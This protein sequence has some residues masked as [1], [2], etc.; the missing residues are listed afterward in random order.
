MY[1]IPGIRAPLFVLA[2]IVLGAAAVA[3]VADDSADEVKLRIGKGD[4]VLG[5]EI[6]VTEL[7]QEC[8]ALD[9]NSHAPATPKLAGQYSQYIIKQLIDLKKGARKHQTMN[10][11]AASLDDADFVD[12]AAYYASLK[13]MKGDAPRNLPKARALFE[14]GDP[15]R[16]VPS[17]VS[18]HGPDGKGLVVGT[19]FNP[20]IGGQQHTYLRGQLVSWKLGERRNSAEGVMNR[21]VQ[22]LSDAEID[23]L[24]DYISGL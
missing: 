19:T 6:A 3:S 9:G 16:G 7:C 17:C 5:R 1:R 23:E 8:H 15:A 11:I 22:P 12:V 14:N 10:I 18:C 2:A 24:A 21:F 20:V 13:K 4:P